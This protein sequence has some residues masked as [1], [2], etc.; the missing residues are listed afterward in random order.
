MYTEPVQLIGEGEYNLNVLSEIQV[1]ESFLGMDEVVRG[2]QNVEPL[3]NCS[4]RH[5]IDTLL[6]ECG[7][8]PFNIRTTDKV[9]CIFFRGIIIQSHN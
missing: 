1:T 4:T 2:C 7:C 9:G 5:H 8:L 3:Y 6:N